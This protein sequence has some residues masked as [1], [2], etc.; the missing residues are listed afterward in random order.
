[1][2]YSA[3]TDLLSSDRVRGIPFQEIKHVVH[4]NLLWSHDQHTEGKCIGISTVWMSH[5]IPVYEQGSVCRCVCLC[6]C[7]WVCVCMCVCVCVCVGVC[8]C[9]CLFVH[10][11]CDILL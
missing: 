8:V 10:Y 4:F 2:I 5:N 7:V 6:V 1:M 3:R 11:L 9:M